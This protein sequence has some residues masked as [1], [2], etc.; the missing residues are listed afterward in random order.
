MNR[1]LNLDILRRLD[2]IGEL[3]PEKPLIQLQQQNVMVDGVTFAD[4][5]R[6]AMD[7]AGQVVEAEGLVCDD[8]DSG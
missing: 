5:L 2:T 6:E 3:I 1:L 4:P 7:G 8:A